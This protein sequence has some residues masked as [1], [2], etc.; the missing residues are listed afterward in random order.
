MGAAAASWPFVSFLPAYCRDWTGLNQEQSFVQTPRL[1]E[2]L[3]I[4]PSN[5]PWSQGLP[6]NNRFVHVHM[7]ERGKTKDSYWAE[8]GWSAGLEFLPQTSLARSSIILFIWCRKAKMGEKQKQR[9]QKPY[10]CVEALMK[11]IITSQLPAATGNKCWASQLLQDI[12]HQDLTICVNRIS[13]GIVY[14]YL[15][16]CDESLQPPLVHHKQ[17]LAPKHGQNPVS[18]EEIPAL[19]Q[20]QYVFSGVVSQHFCAVFTSMCDCMKK[21]EARCKWGAKVLMEIFST[22]E[23]SSLTS[24]STLQTNWRIWGVTI[25]LRIMTT[26]GVVI[27]SHSS[28]LTSWTVALGDSRTDAG[29]MRHTSSRVCTAPPGRNTLET[30]RLAYLMHFSSRRIVVMFAESVQHLQNPK[31]D[32]QQQVNNST[33]P[34]WALDMDPA[35]AVKRGICGISFLFVTFF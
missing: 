34:V 2:V 4:T 29:W 1:I 24:S 25:S 32:S 26:T 35:E 15:S 9:R 14:Y 31:S 12:A 17:R 21:K 5:E 11:T 20:Q 7:Y 19:Q 8:D 18:L 33:A 6:A 27:M 23:S 16:P 28:P 22:A 3:L 30:P 10:G 13:A